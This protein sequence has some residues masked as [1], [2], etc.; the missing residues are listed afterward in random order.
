MVTVALLTL[1]PLPLRVARLACLIHAANVHSEPG[2]NP[3]IKV[4][5]VLKHEAPGRLAPHHFGLRIKTGPWQKTHLDLSTPPNGPRRSE[6]GLLRR[7]PSR[8]RT[9]NAHEPR[10]TRL[11]KRC[12]ERSTDAIGRGFRP[13]GHRLGRNYQRSLPRRPCRLFRRRVAV[14]TGDKDNSTTRSRPV[15]RLVCFFGQLS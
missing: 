8:V 14:L 15:N 11:S 4:E 10:S 6:F 13:F 1:A 12:R 9:D 7:L 3:S 2:S 5:Y